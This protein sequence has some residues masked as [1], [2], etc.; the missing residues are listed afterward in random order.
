MVKNIIEKDIMDL[1]Q[2]YK[3]IICIDLTELLGVMLLVYK[4]HFCKYE[5]SKKLLSLVN[6]DD[7]FISTCS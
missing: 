2:V 6:T 4:K 7:T 5:R 3:G 1:L